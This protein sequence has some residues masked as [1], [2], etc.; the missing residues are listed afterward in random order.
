MYDLFHKLHISNWLYRGYLLSI[1]AFLIAYTK[2]YREKY[3]NVL[4]TLLLAHLSIVC[5][6]LTRNRFSG[7]GIQTLIIILIPALLFG[8][9]PFLKLCFKVIKITGIRQYLLGCC[10]KKQIENDVGNT[11][12]D[13]KA[14]HVQTLKTPTSS[15]IASFKTYGS[16]QYLHNSTG[17]SQ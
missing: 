13:V 11:I 2:P 7:D 15:T 6:L 14:T 16:L 9:L 17:T 5:H 4:D 8:L 12:S 1:A 10:Q 3:M